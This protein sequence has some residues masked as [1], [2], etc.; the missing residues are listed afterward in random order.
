MPYIRR[1]SVTAP[2]TRNEHIVTVQHSVQPS[3]PLH[4]EPV[5]SI[6]GRIDGG[7]IFRS[8]NDRTGAQAPV[9]TRRSTAGRRYLAT[10]SNGVESDNLLSLP[11]Y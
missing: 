10:T 3:G 9:G 6:I 8:H 1:I 7:S 5:S 11:R 2:G 4:S